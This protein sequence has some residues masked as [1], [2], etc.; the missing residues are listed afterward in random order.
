[1]LLEYRVYHLEPFQ[2]VLGGDYVDN[3]VLSAV[4]L[5]ALLL[6][7]FESGGERLLEVFL[8]DAAL[9]EAEP[10]LYVD[11][12]RRPG[13]SLM[14]E[15]HRRV[16]VEIVDHLIVKGLVKI[17]HR[18][19]TVVPVA[20][21]KDN[22]VGSILPYPADAL[23]Y[24]LVPDGDVALI[25]DLVQQL[26]SGVA[27]HFSEAL[28]YLLPEPVKPL[29]QRLALEEAVLV[30]AVIIEGEAGSLVDIYNGVEPVLLRSHYRLLHQREAALLVTAHVVLEYIVIYR[31]PHMVK[32]PGSDSLKVLLLY[33]AVQSLLAVVALGE[34]A[35]E[36]YPSV[37]FHFLKHIFTSFLI[38]QE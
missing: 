32:P 14:G 35:A 5:D 11:H 7:L 3:A 20:A 19:R 25:C 33:E 17:L 9:L 1:M 27:V 15:L 8:G 22:R 10:L 31:Y 6:R 29:L 34:P 18:I 24:H 21:H 16:A 28:R 38:E 30:L 4:D 37:K 26:E 36:V 23:L 2:G 13:C 12:M